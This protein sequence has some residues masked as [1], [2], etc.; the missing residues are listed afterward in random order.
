MVASCSVDEQPAP[1]VPMVIA[2]GAVHTVL[3]PIAAACRQPCTSSWLARAASLKPLLL[4]PFGESIS[5]VRSNP[6]LQHLCGWIDPQV[7]PLQET[8]DLN[9]PGDDGCQLKCDA[10]K[11]LCITPLKLET[12]LVAHSCGLHAC[13]RGH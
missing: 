6:T 4:S 10:T 11:R 7:V 9:T 8:H 3:E 2:F 5:A 13:F 12:P 1:V